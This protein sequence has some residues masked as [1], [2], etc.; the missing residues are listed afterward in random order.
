[1]H[2]RNVVRTNE[3]VRLSIITEH[4]H[5]A[6]KLTYLIQMSKHLLSECNVL[7]VAKLH[8]CLT[9]FTGGCGSGP[10]TREHPSLVLFSN[11]Q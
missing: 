5:A 7:N 2:F 11:D 10:E 9:W 1:M 6:V 8:P 4:F 3:I